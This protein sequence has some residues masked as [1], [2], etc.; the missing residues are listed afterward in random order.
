MRGHPCSSS[1]SSL[2][3]SSHCFSTNITPPHQTVTDLAD[4]ATYPIEHRAKAS[5]MVL[6]KSVTG[7]FGNK[8]VPVYEAKDLYNG[9]NP[10]ATI[11]GDGAELHGFETPV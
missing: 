5:R 10:E 11:T 7:M 6:G 1:L 2:L 9:F 8:K 3:F 4:P